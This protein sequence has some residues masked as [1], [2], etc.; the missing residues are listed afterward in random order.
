MQNA[1]NVVEVRSKN[2]PRL[3]QAVSLLALLSI[4]PAA[5][6]ATY[7]VAT[8]GSDT[9]NGTSL[10]SPFRTIQKAMNTVVAGDVVNVR[11]GTYREEINAYRGGAAGNYVTVQ[12]YN[13]EVPVVKGSEI[14]TGWTLHGGNIWKKTNWGINSQQVFAAG[15]AASLQQIGMPSTMVTSWEYHAPVGSGLSSMRAGS[16]YYDGGAKTLYVWLPDGSNPNNTTMEVSTKR[17]LFYMGAGYIYLKGIAFRHTSTS[18]YTQQ[19][20]AVELG[21]NSI[22]D[23]IDVQYVDFSGVGLGYMKSGG[24]L[25]N[26]N[27]SNNGN[28]GVNG[29]ASYNFRVAG[30]KMNNNNTR[31]FNPLWH[32]GGL[33]A[34]TKAY[35]IVENNEAAY[36]NGS[37]IWCDYCNSGNQ[38]IVR[39]NYVHD[40]GPKDSAIF[41]EVTKNALVYNNVL[42]NNTRRG[43]YLSATDNTR[44][45]NNTIVGTKGHAAIDVHGMPRSGATLTNNVVNNNIVHNNSTLYDI[46]IATPGTGISGNTSDYNNVYRSG[47]NVMMYFGKWYYTVASWALGTRYDTHSLSVNPMFVGGTAVSANNYALQSSSPVI[48]KG[49]TLAAVPNDYLNNKRPGGGA[50]D[51]GAFESGATTSTT[52]P[53]TTTSGTDTIAPVASITSPA[54]DGTWVRGSVSIAAS[55][56]DNVAV[57]SMRLYIDGVVKAESVGNK[58]SYVWSTAGA[59]LGTHTIM[60][61]AWDGRNSSRTFRTMKVY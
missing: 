43:I 39:N 13:G 18:A 28:S 42:V 2:T 19:G 46:N 52:T 14:V 51:M 60:V 17:R 47:G 27:L 23:K 35:G 57:K 15:R 29:P 3:R 58:I 50:Y 61:S 5:W 48:N 30:N 6:S 33:K 1:S 12:G 9:A 45:Y 11:G 26:S 4:T 31:N 37:G 54:Q 36:N 22:A 56:T 24:Q 59:K 7:Y 21:A 44:V 38:I 34:T 25:I 55:A 49:L 41:L 16:F 32:G 53:T 20:S 8:N 10:T 40:N